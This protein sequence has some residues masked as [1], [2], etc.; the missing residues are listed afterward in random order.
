MR[1]S[2]SFMRCMMTAS[3]SSG[4]FCFLDFAMP[5]PGDK[6]KVFATIRDPKHDRA[7]AAALGDMIVA[8]A[9]AERVLHDIMHRMTKMS[10][11]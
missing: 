10:Y 1:L 7:L 3:S 4:S 6:H 8:W 2:A 11:L 9:D 5:D